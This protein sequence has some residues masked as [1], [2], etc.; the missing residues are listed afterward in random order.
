LPIKGGRFRE[1]NNVISTPIAL[2]ATEYKGSNTPFQ[3][4]LLLLDLPK[5]QK[6]KKSKK[7]YNI[8]KLYW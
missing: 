7:C 6:K 8:H 4:P 2:E 5:L 3:K 1:E